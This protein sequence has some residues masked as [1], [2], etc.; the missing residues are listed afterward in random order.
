MIDGLPTDHVVP[1]LHVWLGLRGSLI[2]QTDG[3]LT[4]KTA[5]AYMHRVLEIETP[6]TYPTFL[7]NNYH[8]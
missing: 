5:L 4:A 1:I 3:I 6:A 8:R 7:G 2:R